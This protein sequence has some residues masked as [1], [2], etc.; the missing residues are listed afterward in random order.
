MDLFHVAI[1][2]ETGADAFLTFDKDQEILASRGGVT[3]IE[4]TM[5]L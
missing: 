2:I 5:N 3:T 4:L 1:A